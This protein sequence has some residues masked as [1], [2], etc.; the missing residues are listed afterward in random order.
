MAD[1]AGFNAV[2]SPH[3]AL[4]MAMRTKREIYPFFDL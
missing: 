2:W 4:T 3:L 1:M